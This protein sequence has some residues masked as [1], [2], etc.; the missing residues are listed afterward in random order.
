[1]EEDDKE[2]M[3]CRLPSLHPLDVPVSI[4]NFVKFGPRDV[5]A[6]VIIRAHKQADKEIID[7]IARRQRSTT[8]YC[9]PICSTATMASS[10]ASSSRCPRQ[11]LLHTHPCRKRRLHLHSQHRSCESPPCTCKPIP[12]LNQVSARVLMLHLSFLLPMRNSLRL[13]LLHVRLVR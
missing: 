2:W 8:P 9:H 10:Q 5:C 13:G 11:P 1:M 4:L 6:C 7:M 3:R 12:A